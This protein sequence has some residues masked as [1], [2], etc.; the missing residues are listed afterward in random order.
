M[1]QEIRIV[2]GVQKL[3]HKTVNLADCQFT[4]AHVALLSLS[5]SD[6]NNN[7]LIIF[8]FVINNFYR[9]IFLVCFQQHVG[10]CEGNMTT[11]LA[12]ELLV[13]V[14]LRFTFLVAA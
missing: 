1:F 9:Q 8:V 7:L 14:D 11:I 12:N 2:Y 4:D 13:L 3:P 5:S 10:G 6:Y